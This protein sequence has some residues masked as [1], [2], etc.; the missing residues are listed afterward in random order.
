MQY[1]ER[2]VSEAMET[3]PALWALKHSIRTST[4]LPFEFRDRR[5][6][7]DFLNDLS[8]LQCMLK[9]PQIGATESE[10]V[11]A[12]WVAHK[13]RR[14]IIYT[15]P[16]QSDVNEMAGGKVNR[17][18][19]QNPVL[20]SWVKDH[21][22]VF[23]K[24]VGDNIIYYRGTFSNKQAMM[25]SSQ[26]NIH[27]E[28]DASDPSVITQYETRLEAQKGGWRWYFSHPS[29][30][31]YGV[32]IYWEQ[33][34]KKEWFVAHSCGARFA[35]EWPRN[36]DRD[37]RTFRCHECGGEITDDERRMG[38][39][40]RTAKGPFSGWHVSQLMC[41]WIDA[42]NILDKRDDPQKDEQYFWNYVLGL[43]YVGSANRIEPSQVLANCDPRANSQ[44]PTVVIGVDTGLPVHY[45]LMN[46][47]GAFYARKCDT[48]SADYDPYAEIERMLLRFPNSVV[49]ADQGGD[50]I[51]IR[52]LQAK[53]R[54]RVFLCHY[55][56]DRKTTELAHWDLQ[57]GSVTVDRNRLITLVVEM[58]KEGGRIALS[59]T[60]SDWAEVAR[61]FGNIRREVEET[62]FGPKHEWKRDGKPDHFVHALCYAVVGLQ[63]FREEAAII[64]GA[65]KLDGIHRG[66]LAP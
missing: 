16:T 48:V 35:M 46:K 27:D 55:R 39:W 20:R 56:P 6:M 15:L 47:E 7:W 52:K 58:L 12:F 30:K 11:K 31:G 45:V 40:M 18:V 29:V 17:I 36:V 10:I 42:G 19:A 5:F 38:Q 26:L 22:T 60:E 43:P 33:S 14:D 66:I 21:D 50:L 4:G 28:V 2:E 49:V 3:L 65:G 64:V 25:V 63:R 59:G 23:Q 54:G 57:D 13:L 24:S 8:P 32:D 53:H 9:P 41:P 1:S 62:Q 51:G 37:T 44:S 61:H 34:D